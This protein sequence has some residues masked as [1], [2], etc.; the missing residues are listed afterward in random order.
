MIYKNTKY[1]FSFEIPL[2]WTQEPSGLIVKVIHIFTAGA[3]PEVVMHSP[4]DEANM[5]VFCSSIPPEIAKV[6]TRERSMLHWALESRLE[7]EKTGQYTD[8]LGRE[9]NTVEMRYRY[10]SQIP[11]KA[12][13]KISSVRRGIEYCMTLCGDHKKYEHDFKKFKDTFIFL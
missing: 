7:I 6:E 11:N 9:E 10:P 1:G 2:G 13:T 4:K 3:I 8:I 12:I 5:N